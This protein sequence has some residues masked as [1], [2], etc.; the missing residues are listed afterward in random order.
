[1]AATAPKGPR[2]SLSGWTKRSISLKEEST[3][4]R[5]GL[6]RVEIVGRFGPGGASTW[7]DCCQ[8]VQVVEAD[9][10]SQLDS[11]NLKEFLLLAMN[12]CD[13][14]GRQRCAREPERNWQAISQLHRECGNC[15]VL[16]QS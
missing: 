12:R 2:Q 11:V 16:G 14:V 3:P 8:C 1:M 9:R 4:R 10:C 7:R 13:N 15:C 5:H 6:S